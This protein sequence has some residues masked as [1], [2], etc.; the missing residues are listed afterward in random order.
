MKSRPQNS[1]EKLSRRKFR[2]GR[3]AS[4]LVSRWQ[5]HHRRNRRGMLDATRDHVGRNRLAARFHRRPTIGRS[6]VGA[7][8][9]DPRLVACRDPRKGRG[10]LVHEAIPR[11]YSTAVQI[12]PPWS[13]GFEV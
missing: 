1:I 13:V 9:H 12:E 11:C 2:L 6:R 7:P 5:G 8:D 10:L 3:T 4:N